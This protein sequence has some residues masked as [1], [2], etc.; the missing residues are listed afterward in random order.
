MGFAN[1]WQFGGAEK[2]QG[3]CILRAEE[4]ST[5]AIV[6]SAEERQRG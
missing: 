4:G 2:G 6:G 1:D 3:R 5:E